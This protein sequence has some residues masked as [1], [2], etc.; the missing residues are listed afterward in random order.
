MNTKY[1]TILFI[2]GIASVIGCSKSLK[3]DGFPP[4]YPASIMVIQD[5]QPLEGASV[6]LFRVDDSPQKWGIAGVTDKGGRAV[7]LTHG[8][9]SGVP[10]GEYAVTVNKAEEVEVSHR[11][12]STV[13]ESFTL[14]EKQHV[15]K[16][17][18]PLR[19]QIQKKGKNYKEFDV[20]KPVHISLGRNTA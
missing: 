2:L 3:P 1:I 9:H 18:T 13:T 12:E 20:G 15:D 4:L 8:I 11:A 6:I 14:I 19:I 5:G 7:L 17:S 10:E 16:E